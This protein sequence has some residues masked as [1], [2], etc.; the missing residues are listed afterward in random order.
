MAYL[1]HECLVYALLPFFVLNNTSS[2]TGTRWQLT[3]ETYNKCD[4]VCM[5]SQQQIQEMIFIKYV[6]SSEV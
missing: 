5:H 6:F 2:T 1:S 3:V 4:A